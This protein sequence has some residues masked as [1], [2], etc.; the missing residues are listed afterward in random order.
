MYHAVK[1]SYYLLL[2][3]IAIMFFAV[4]SLM[5]FPVAMY[6]SDSGAVNYY[7]KHPHP[8]IDKSIYYV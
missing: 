7:Y 3:I 2:S 6:I 5:V 4:L 1:I 8:N